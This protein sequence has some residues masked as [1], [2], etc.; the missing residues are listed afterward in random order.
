MTTHRQYW[1]DAI[2]ANGDMALNPRKGKRAFESLIAE[3]G[4]EDGMIFYERGEAHEYLQELDNALEDYDKAEAK[5]PLSS[6]K[7]VARI[8]QLRIKGK[9]QNPLRIPFGPHPW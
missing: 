2:K 4:G 7:E 1:I 6:W 9:K 5:M 8:G 3:T